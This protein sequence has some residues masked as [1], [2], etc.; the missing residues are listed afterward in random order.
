M[1]SF[2]C[3]VTLTPVEFKQF[4]RTVQDRRL[5]HDQ[6]DVMLIAALSEK[7]TPDQLVLLNRARP[8]V[9]HSAFFKVRDVHVADD[10]SMVVT[11]AFVL[12]VKTR[13]VKRIFDEQSDTENLAEGDMLGYMSLFCP[14]DT[15][16]GPMVRAIRR[17]NGTLMDEDPVGV[18][19]HDRIRIVISSVP[20]ER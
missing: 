18:S 20:D 15:R 16:T 14:I 7:Y 9:F 11:Y 8:P 17:K 1:K 19:R 4:N 10:G 3:E 12:P 2:S 6:L 5:G 13:L